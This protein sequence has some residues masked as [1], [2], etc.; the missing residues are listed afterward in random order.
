MAWADIGF[1]VAT[2]SAAIAAVT[3]AATLVY[4]AIQFHASQRAVGSMQAQRYPKRP[5]LIM[6][7][8]VLA[9]WGAVGIDYYDRHHEFP[10]DMVLGWGLNGPNSFYMTVNGTYLNAYARDYKMGFILN[11]PYTNIDKVTDT[12]IGKSDLFTITS[13]TQ[14]IGRVGTEWIRAPLGVAN[15]NVSYYLVVVPNGFTMDEIKNL[16]DLLKIGGRIITSR[17]RGDQFTTVP[18]IPPAGAPTSSPPR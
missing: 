17:G 3:G 13:D 4:T 7:L 2:T 16:Q 12:A 10:E 11:V 9:S 15:L 1:W 6:G 5:L 18:I 14:N 8:M